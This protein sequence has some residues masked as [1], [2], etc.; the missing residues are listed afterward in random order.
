VNAK[1]YPM[2]A[3]AP[4]VAEVLGLDRPDTMEADSIACV[5]DDLSVV[6]RVAVLGIDA[7]GLKQFEHWR[8]RM[9][10]VGSL[11][12]KRFATLRSILP[13]VTPVNFGCM[14]TGAEVVVH[15]ARTRDDTFTCPSLFSLL[16]EAGRKSAGLGRAGYTGDGLLGRHAELSAQDM[17]ETDKDVEDIFV[18][19]VA[20]ELPD[21]AIVQLGGTD[22]VFHGYGPYSAEAGD[23]LA[24]A[25]A[26]VR[27]CTDMLLTEGY[28]VLILADHGQSPV[29]GAEGELRGS[30][31]TGSDADSLVPLTW[32][33]PGL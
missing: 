3:V 1:E 25:D 28:G 18:D 19:M 32:T 2:Q 33:R 8:E 16:R 7:W 29:D 15:G 13:S 17:A 5:V 14:V 31:G 12:E 30:H 6:K 24:E 9:P 11:V 21:F 27:R 10:F 22:D 23:A 20:H 4:T 26:W